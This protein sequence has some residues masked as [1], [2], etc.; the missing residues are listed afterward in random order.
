MNLIQKNLDR[1]LNDHAF[2]RLLGEHEICFLSDFILNKEGINSFWQTYYGDSVSRV[3]ICGINP[4]RHGAG[5]TG[6]PFVDFQSLAQL[7][8]GVDRQDS[9]R[10]A[11]FF[12]QVVRQFGVEDFFNSFYVTNVSSVGFMRDGKNLNH[13]ELPESAL[14]VVERNF[15]QEMA[16]IQP[17]HVISLGEVVQNSVRTLLP[18]SVDCSMR[19]P[20]PAWVTSYR[21]K[22]MHEWTNRYLSML[23]KF[24][25]P[26]LA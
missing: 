3:V 18:A 7:I 5:K 12:F 4:G 9:E 6:I 20:H 19:L 1:Y 17:T 15:M 22:E 2:L 23:G 21:G 16:I 13:N 8:T 14:T 24:R 25:Q 11:K 10:S 26:Q